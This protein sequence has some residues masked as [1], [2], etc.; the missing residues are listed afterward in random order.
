MSKVFRILINV[1]LAIFFVWSGA[2]II[3]YLA[4][5]WDKL[6]R[7]QYKNMNDREAVYF[8][9]LALVFVM[10]DVLIIRH[11]IGAMKTK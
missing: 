2:L 8:G 11:F 5:L 3:I 10:V 4:L 7:P 6:A 9:L 1:G